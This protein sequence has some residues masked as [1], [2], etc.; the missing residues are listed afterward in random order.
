[1]KNKLKINSSED[2]LNR[3][4]ERVKQYREVMILRYRSG[5][6]DNKISKITGIPRSLISGWIYKK[7]DH[8]Y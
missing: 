1:L 7:P 6:C 2:L 8:I 3:H 4:L 5:F